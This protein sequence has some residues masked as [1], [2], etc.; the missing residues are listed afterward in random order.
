MV[1]L[2][3]R[4][5]KLSRADVCR[6]WQEN[7][8]KHGW[9]SGTTAEVFVAALLAELDREPEVVNARDL[10]REPDGSPPIIVVSRVRRCQCESPVIRCDH[11]GCRCTVCGEPG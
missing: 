10:P 6:L 9:P 2:A 5:R 11:L 3:P 4:R 8:K 1:S 7:V